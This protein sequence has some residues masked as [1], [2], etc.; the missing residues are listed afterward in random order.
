VLRVFKQVGLALLALILVFGIVLFFGA[1]RKSNL[2]SLPL[3]NPNGY[4]DFLQAA[5][6]VVTSSVADVRT[7]PIE[8]HRA[9][10]E[11]NGN[12][13]ALVRVGLGKE[14]RVPVQFTE[15]YA[16]SAANDVA[17]MKAM[18]VL[19][20]DEGRLAQRE[21]RTN[22][23]LRSFEDGLQFAE[24][25]SRGGM[26]IHRLVAIASRAIMLQEIRNLVDGLNLSQMRKL[27]EALAD[28]DRKAEPAS[29]FIEREKA[30][31]E[32]VYGPIQTLWGRLVL[33]KMLRQSHDTFR[34][35]HDRSQAELRLLRTDIALRLFRSGR[36]KFPRKL[37]ELIPNH[38]D[39]IPLDPF[40]G[41]PLV[42]EWRTNSYLL[43]SIGPD[44]KDDRGTPLTR[45]TQEKGDLV[46]TP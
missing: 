11:Q 15:Q 20:R 33:R 13:L 46:S 30:L 3:P 37:D 24:G 8:Q 35:R 12:A 2:A 39:S 7:L 26:M 22:D 16:Q 21:G 31:M 27:A 45:S 42:Y 23:A 9:F 1:S 36:G 32:A 19:L 10:I 28:L 29:T 41:K 4:D 5:Q 43:Y 6:W 14:T 40:S 18:A 34:A 44:G 38:L 17:P 25:F